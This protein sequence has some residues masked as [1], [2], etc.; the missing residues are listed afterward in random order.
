MDVHVRVDIDEEGPVVVKSASGAAVDRLRREHDRL[1]RAVHPGVVALARRQP[2][3]AHRSPDRPDP[4]D[5]GP[6][7]RGS[8]DPGPADHGPDDPGP[9]D[10]GPGG[11]RSGHPGSVG[12]SDTYHL[13]IRY[14]G[15]PV[16]RWTGTVSGIAGLGTAV[17]GT[18]ADLHAL[19]IV[20]GRIDGSHILIGDDSR[21]RLCGLSHEGDAAPADD[22][23]ALAAVLADLLDRAPAGRWRRPRGST[24]AARALRQTIERAIDPVP[25][26]RPS[27]GALAEAILDAVPGADLPPPIGSGG[28]RGPR[29]GPR[30]GRPG[31][32]DDG[33]NGSEAPQRGTAAQQDTLDRI[34][35]VAGEQ[36][37]DE[38]WA[39]AFGR[40]PR[41]LPAG[42]VPSHAPAGA[43]GPPRGARNT[44][45]DT[46][47]GDEPPP[48]PIARVDS[49]AWSTAPADDDGSPWEGWHRSPGHRGHDITRDHALGPRN[50]PVEDTGLGDA[51]QRVRDIARND[52]D[53]GLGD[54]DLSDADAGHD[55]DI[56]GEPGE[57]LMLGERTDGLPRRDGSPDR[58]DRLRTGPMGRRDRPTSGGSHDG[59]AGEDAD[60]ADDLLTRD[61]RVPVPRVARPSEDDDPDAPHPIRRVVVVAALAAATC[62]AVAGAVMVWTQGDGEAGDAP[63]AEAAAR[64][65]DCPATVPPAADVD[66]D[67]CAE[68][69]AVDGS[70]VDAGVARWTLGEPGDVVAVGDWDCD[71]EASAALL[72]PTTGDVFL[73]SAWA[74][75]DEPVTVGVSQRVEGGVGMRAQPG[76]GGCDRLLVEHA[77]GTATTV[78][79]TG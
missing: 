56:T 77:D 38:R 10:H 24:G 55:A 42:G 31:K 48:L 2:D 30:G 69:L 34:W 59:W 9:A 39:A 22:V 53:R 5:P 79:V 11:A 54:G 28:D 12:D 14:A 8:D 27:A 35:S 3:P 7:D 45:P 17:A 25:T 36:S 16:S 62:L 33:D 70:T 23:A 78:E 44:G 40:G 21:P 51:D 37:E 60:Q 13:H 61:H 75:A 29:L 49:L 76:D 19:G 50:E 47:P 64:P 74:P 52:A 32:G 46:A 71:G 1:R 18:L 26:R 6:A 4:A 57:R 72:R 66:G 68:A 15:E 58:L 67:G 65:A 20:H 73:F 63:G 43:S 41:D